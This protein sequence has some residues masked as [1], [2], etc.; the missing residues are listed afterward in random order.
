MQRMQLRVMSGEKAIEALTKLLSRNKI[1]GQLG[2]VDGS[3]SLSLDKEYQSIGEQL[4]NTFSLNRVLEGYPPEVWSDEDWEKLKGLSEEGFYVV[5]KG[6][7]YYTKETFEIKYVT[8]ESEEIIDNIPAFMEIFMDSDSDLFRAFSLDNFFESNMELIKD[9]RLKTFNYQKTLDN[10][11]LKIKEKQQTIGLTIVDSQE[12]LEAKGYWDVFTR[13]RLIDRNEI[14]MYLAYIVMDKVS[15]GVSLKKSLEECTDISPVE[16]EIIYNFYGLYKEYLDFVNN[17]IDANNLTEGFTK[18]EER[19]SDFD[20]DFEFETSETAQIHL[21]FSQFVS[22]NLDISLSESAIKDILKRKFKTVLDFKLKGLSIMKETLTQNKRA[23][24]AVCTYNMETQEEKDEFI[25]VAQQVLEESK[26]FY[27]E[28]KSKEL[29]TLLFKNFN[30]Q[31]IPPYVKIL[32]KMV[33]PKQVLLR[34]TEGT[35]SRE[36]IIAKFKGDYQEPLFVVTNISEI[37]YQMKTFEDNK[38]LTK[39][40]L[41]DLSKYICEKVD[42][43]TKL[44]LRERNVEEVAKIYTHIF[45]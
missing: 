6:V 38:V 2:I 29:E 21:L 12:V 43:Y 37:L 14:Q 39:A 20:L 44:Q 35:V 32:K 22:E 9:M 5:S 10:I 40:M 42:I 23:L 15:R 25:M 16:F 26:E 34:S 30:A 13:H 45:K 7:I 19:Y 36:E 24:V 1:E 31:N 8:E 28:L 18:I 27:K 17:T 4:L 11:I 33:E 41:K 3:I